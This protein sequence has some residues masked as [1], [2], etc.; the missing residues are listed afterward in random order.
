MAIQTETFRRAPDVHIIVSVDKMSYPCVSVFSGH[1]KPEASLISTLSIGIA[2]GTIPTLRKLFSGCQRVTSPL[3]VCPFLITSP[4]QKEISSKNRHSTIEP[5]SILE[6][7]SQSVHKP[8]LFNSRNGSPQS[9][10]ACSS[11]TSL[12]Q[13]QPHVQIESPQRLQMCLSHPYPQ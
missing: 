11:Q 10:Q 3:K 8:S 9:T 13:S 7:G 4:P 12:A 6:S 2:S 5:T 1:C